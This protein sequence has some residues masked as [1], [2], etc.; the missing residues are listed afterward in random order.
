MADRN[1]VQ[2]A[3]AKFSAKILPRGQS[4]CHRNTDLVRTYYTITDAC[5]TEKDQAK[6]GI[7]QYGINGAFSLDDLHRPVQIP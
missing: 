1:N 4:K 3:Q 6:M 5:C 2:E 7:L